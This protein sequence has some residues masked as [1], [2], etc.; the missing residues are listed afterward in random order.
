MTNATGL[1]VSAETF[2]NAR[3]DTYALLAALLNRPPDLYL[4]LQ[5]QYLDCD[6]G[7]PVSLI[8]GW[9]ELRNAARRYP[10]DAV[11]E[12]FLDVFVGLGQGDVVPYA[13]WYLEGL[14]MT[15]PLSRLRMD[16]TRFGIARRKNVYEAEDHAGLLCETMALLGRDGDVSG[17]DYARFFDQHV[18]CWMFDFF[19]D[20]RHAPS[21]GFYRSVGR[22]GKC[23][24]ELEQIC[25]HSHCAAATD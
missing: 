7:I 22:L 21:A 11:A 24:L 4:S 10:V 8:E 13:S 23:L 17:E 6:P 16:L 14:L 2:R 20:L 12:E 18:A 1:S 5:L 25:L 3:T 9:I 19:D 15:S